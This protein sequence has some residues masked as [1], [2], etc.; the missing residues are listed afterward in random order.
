[1]SF[2]IP[3]TGQA[4]ANAL[5]KTLTEI[6]VEEFSILQ[7]ILKTIKADTDAWRKFRKYLQAYRDIR[8]AFIEGARNRPKESKKRLRCLAKNDRGEV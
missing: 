2:G 3:L 4:A 7:N 6:G 5:L 8:I 1:V